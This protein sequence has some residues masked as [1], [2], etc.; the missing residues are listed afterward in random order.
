MNSPPDTVDQVFQWLRKVFGVYLP[1]LP[2]AKGWR[3]LAGLFGIAVDP[4]L[5]APT[6][7]LPWDLPLAEQWPLPLPGVKV[8]L[9]DLRIHVAERTPA[10]AN[11]SLPPTAP[12]EE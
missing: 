5:P 6:D 2:L 7:P 8:S 1:T 9:T 3:R 4:P 11:D 12:T 10:A